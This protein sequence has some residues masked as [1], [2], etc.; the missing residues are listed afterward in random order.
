MLLADFNYYKK[1]EH[2]KNFSIIFDFRLPSSK[3]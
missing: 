3:I 1:I 2:G